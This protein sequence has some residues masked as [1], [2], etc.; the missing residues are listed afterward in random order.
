MSEEQ[1]QTIEVAEEAAAPEGI[2]KTSPTRASVK[3]L[4]WSKQEIDAAEKRG[5]LEKP[6]DAEAQEK[7]VAAKRIEAD[8]T[9]ATKKP[10]VKLPS[11][12]LDD[13]DAE[14]TPAQEKVFLE[15]FPPGTKPRAFYFRAKN[16]RAQRQRAEAERDKFA[17]ELQLRKDRD[18]KPLNAEPEVERD[19]DGNV[20]NPDE[21]PLTMKQLKAMQKL[22]MD[23]MNRKRDELQQRSAK[24]SEALTTQEEYAKST[25]PDFEDTV[26]LAT[27]L[28][29]NLDQLEDPVKKSRAVKLIKDLQVAAAT[30]DKYGVDDYTASMIAYEMGQMHPKYGQKADP[31]GPPKVEPKNGALTPEQMRKVEENAKRRA[32][33][34]SL[35]GGNGKRAIAVEDVTIKD[36]LKMTPEARYAFK[37]KYPE[38]ME[39]LLRG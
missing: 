6:E 32:S 37:K 2:I 34:A 33:S 35:P 23:E 20:I 25:L 22:E 14:L 15:N 28:V 10:E 16:E 30:A 27:D 31:D 7:E 1:A 3:E 18:A 38:R 36:V 17:L 26:K 9:V 21:K 12:F 13:M 19:A 8:K 5:M 4:G 39:K 24:V 29:N 11:N